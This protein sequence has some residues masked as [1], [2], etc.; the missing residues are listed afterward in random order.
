MP[1]TIAAETEALVGLVGDGTADKNNFISLHTADPGSNGASEVTGGAY[2]R[3]QTD[4]PAPANASVTG[5]AVTLDV[6]AGTT[7]THWGLWKQAGP[8][9]TFLYGAP[10][11]APETFGSNGTY[12]VT[13]TLAAGD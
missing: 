8:G 5:S 9:G 11:P 12:S 2:T 6:P 3:E 13:P 1:F 10:L 4:W 7:I